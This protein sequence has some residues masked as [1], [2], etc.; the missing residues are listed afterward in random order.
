M[1]DNILKTVIDKQVIEFKLLQ[2]PSIEDITPENNLI[3]ID[4]GDIKVLSHKK[5][6]DEYRLSIFVDVLKKINLSNIKCSFLL[7]TLDVS[8]NNNKKTICFSKKRHQ[9]FIT[10]PNIHVI[11][12][13]VNYFIRQVNNYDISYDKKINKSLFCGS[14]TGKKS[15]SYLGKRIQYISDTLYNN[16]RNNHVCLLVNNSI[17]GIDYQLQFKYL[18]NIDGDSCSWDRIY[19]QMYSNSL[20]WYYKRDNSIVELYHELIKE[21]IHYIP[22]DEKLNIVYDFF[23]NDVSSIDFRNSIINNGK[24]F[25]QKYFLNENNNYTNIIE[26]IINSIK[27]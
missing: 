12:G 19:W 1:I 4:N 21:N 17:M 2:D 26:Y 10:A 25:I 11:L 14:P 27:L 6:Q 24:N 5:P 8:E 9:S 23:E 3:I 18:V 7:N 13:A 22:V 20:T 16:I 15:S